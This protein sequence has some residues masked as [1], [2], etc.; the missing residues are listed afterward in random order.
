MNGFGFIEYED[1]MDARDIVPGQSH[2][3]SPALVVL[4]TDICPPSIPYEPHLIHSSPTKFDQECR[5]QRL[6]GRAPDSPIRSWPTSQ[7][8][9]QWTSRSQRSTPSST[10]YLSH[11]YHWA[12]NRYQLAGQNFQ[13]FLTP[14]I[15]GSYIIVQHGCHLRSCPT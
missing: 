7:R 11:E 10:Y 9:F 5:W 1:A 14:D 8:E 4:N 15:M 2:Y 3:T 12:T 13:P 6:Q